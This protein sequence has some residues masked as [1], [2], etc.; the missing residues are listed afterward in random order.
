MVLGF[1][2]VV[3]HLTVFSKT[4]N[5]SNNDQMIK[6]KK[7][8]TC[9]DFKNIDDFNKDS[10]KKDGLMNV[11]KVCKKRWTIAHHRTKLGLLKDMYH[12]QSTRSKKYYYKIVDYTRTE[13]I[14]CYIN[15]DDYNNLFKQ[16][17]LSGYKKDLI[18]SIDRINSKLGYSLNNTQFMTWKDN[19]LKNYKEMKNCDVHNPRYSK[20]KQYDLKGNY[21]NEYNSIAHA[22]RDND[23]YYT[24]I[25]CVCNGTKKT[26]GAY[27][28]CFSDKELILNNHIKRVKSSEVSCY[29][30]ENNLIKTYK[31][32]KDIEDDGYTKV[33]VHKSLNTG[34][35]YFGNYWKRTNFLK[36]RSDYEPT[37]ILG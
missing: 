21:I 37:N 4:T 7:C 27:I 33:S 23:I 36:E 25:S 10:S 28:W 2:L 30:S 12:D 17:E 13:F 20:V 8:S 24:S 32:L 1:Y 34:K 26:A 9:G 35:P 5:E 11:C 6:E 22:S 19:K 14:D 29:D 31:M 3:S 18:P 15:S 16:W